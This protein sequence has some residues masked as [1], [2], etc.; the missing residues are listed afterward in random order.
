VKGEKER[1]MRTGISKAWTFGFALATLGAVAAAALGQTQQGTTAP[2]LPQP[3]MATKPSVWVENRGAEQAVPIT[4]ERVTAPL[5]VQVVGVPT[6]ALSSETILTTRPVRLGWEYRT[7][8]V[9]AGTDPSGELNAAGAEG[10][11]VVGVLVA[12]RQATALL[13]KRAR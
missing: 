6:F 2:G 12:D 11:E 9:K 5:N 13:L 3:G 1:T 8:T 4:V 10:W 7:L